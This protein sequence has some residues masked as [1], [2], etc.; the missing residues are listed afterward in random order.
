MIDGCL[1]KMKVWIWTKRMA[2]VEHKSINERAYLIRQLKAQAMATYFAKLYVCIIEI[3]AITY[4]LKATKR[5]ESLLERDETRHK[6]FS[7]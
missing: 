6:T 5:F 4:I 1:F 3:N 2:K 7:T